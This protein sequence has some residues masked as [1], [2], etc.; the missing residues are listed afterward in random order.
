MLQVD[1]ARGL[2]YFVG[3]RETPLERHL[4]VTSYDPPA[5]QRVTLLTTVGHSHS[6]DMDEVGYNILSRYSL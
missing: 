1:E 2:V 5:P 4:Y 3:L 6:V